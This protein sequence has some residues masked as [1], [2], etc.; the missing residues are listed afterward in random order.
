[1]QFEW[2]DSKTEK[3]LKSMEFLFIQRYLFSRM[4]TE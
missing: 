4:M 3:T 1:M 2:D